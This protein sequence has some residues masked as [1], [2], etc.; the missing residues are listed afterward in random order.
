[1]RVPSPLVNERLFDRRCQ[2]AAC[3]D[4]KRSTSH[5]RIEHAQREDLVGRAAANQ[6]LERL[7][8]EIRR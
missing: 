3:R 7:A 6:W 8:Y 2:V 4:E 5:R 1:M